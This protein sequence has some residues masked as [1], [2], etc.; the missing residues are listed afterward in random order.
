MIRETRG[1]GIQGRTRVHLG[2][3]VWSERKSESENDG[4][5]CVV[6][7]DDGALVKVSG[8]ESESESGL[9]RSERRT[10]AAGA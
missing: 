4:V 10:A 8:S 2:G 3:G 1:R 5:D 9:H 6:G 7:G